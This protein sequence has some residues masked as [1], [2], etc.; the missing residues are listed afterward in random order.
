MTKS[1][2][3]PAIAHHVRIEVADLIQFYEPLKTFP[4][5]KAIARHENGKTGEHPHLHVFF[6]L[7]RELTRV[8]L[9]NRLKA[10]HDVFKSLY[11][12]AQ[13][14]CKAHDSYTNWCR[15][16][17]G[18]L[19]HSIIKSDEELD[20]IHEEVPK[21]PFVANGLLQSPGVPPARPIVVRK[22]RAMRD[23]FIDY[24]EKER[25]WKV[26][27]HFIITPETPAS[28]WSSC[29][30]EVIEAATEYWE[31]AFSFP[32]GERMCRYALWKFSCDEMRE[33]IKEKMVER[34][35]KSLW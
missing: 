33:V 24:L 2:D 15:Y 22:S 21:V 1:D 28:Y 35:K 7:E 18:N 17:C 14:R 27:Q 25:K 5:V 10:H 29:E 32:E 30:R 8:A 9:K 12:N 19:S 11:G 31:A 34:I 20:K 26:N 13:W 3:P 16:V 6:Q 4:G 23:R